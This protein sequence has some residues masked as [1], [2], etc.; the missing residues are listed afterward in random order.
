MKKIFYPEWIN[1]IPSND[2]VLEE[3]QK[4]AREEL[5]QN[6]IP[7]KS[8]EE[9]RLTNSALVKEFF[10]LPLNSNNTKL[11]LNRIDNLRRSLVKLKFDND[12]IF[13]ANLCNGIE[14]L[15]EEEIKLYLSENSIRRKDFYDFNK[16]IN[17]ASNNRLIGFKINS[18]EI[19]SLEIDIKAEVSELVPT[20]VIIIVEEGLKIDILEI[21]EGS[22]AASHSHLIEIYIK[23][24]STVNHAIV[25]IG[26]DSAKLMASILVNQEK[27]S[28]Y[29][30]TC[31]QKGWAFSRLEQKIIQL[32]G[33]AKTNIQGLQIAN[34][35][36]ELATHSRVKFNGPNGYLKQIQ[37]SIL[38]DESHSIFNGMI[39]VP[40]IAQ[41]TEASQLSKNLLLSSKAKVDTS[42]QLKIIADDVKCNHGATISQLSNEELFYLQSRGINI[43]KAN[44]L[45]INAFCNEILDNLSIQESAW[46]LLPK[47]LENIKSQ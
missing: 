7:K 33:N 26:K 18:K 34:N 38:D 28:N 29:S 11:K 3:T 35:Q 41:R 32:N 23:D 5:K 43:K 12:S 36:Q 8:S 45:L 47:A 4:L 37:K 44:Q 40:K 46:S 17:E 22:R 25:S 15:S 31:I 9:W 16:S 42:P 2:G 1:S 20:R 10:N 30:L 6:G 39:E 13:E 21:I 27:Q 24:F 19:K 14:K